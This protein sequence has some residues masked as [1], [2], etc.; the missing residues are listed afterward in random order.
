MKMNRFFTGLVALVAGL[1]L[2]AGSALATKGYL[3]GD[4]DTM[5]VIPHYEVGYGKATIIGISNL[6]S[7]DANDTECFARA[8]PGTIDAPFD[9]TLI[10]TAGNT[11]P[12]DSAIA[13]DAAAPTDGTTFIRQYAN[14]QATAN[15]DANADDPMNLI[16]T[17]NI[18]DASGAMVD[19]EQLC[20]NENQFGY[21][22]IQMGEAM[23]GQMIPH[24]GAVVSMMDDDMMD[25]DMMPRGYATIEATARIDE[26]A[27]GYVTP[28][29][30]VTAGDSVMP[31]IAA[32]TIVQDV[33]ENGFFGTEVPTGTLSMREDDGAMVADCYN[34]DGTTE[35]PTDLTDN[36]FN[37]HKCGLIPERH[38]TA[39]IGTDDTTTAADERMNPDPAEATPRAHVTARY[40]I[41][42]D[43]M[44][45]VWLAAEPSAPLEVMVLCE[46][47][48]QTA[49]DDPS[50]NVPTTDLPT[51][52]IAVSMGTTIIDPS[53]GEVGDFTGM[54]D[55]TRGTLRFAMPDDSH[56]GMVWTHLS[57]EMNHFRMNFPG[58]SLANPSNCNTVA[59][60]SLDPADTGAGVCE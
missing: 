57:Q 28:D 38:N 58:Y 20:L 51:A 10:T 46:E 5:K 9:T 3:S 21:V 37:Q 35:T 47:G 44:V 2:S 25:G 39:R 48:P 60:A 34:P 11:C 26:C 13:V 29:E 14:Y 18:H 15:M 41:G 4:P 7:G 43:S 31:M 33:S 50:S 45:Y 54:C 55:G 53:M 27:E 56:A 32:W 6:E 40:D 36:E 8:D 22:V 12:Y 16:V 17:M 30:A 24:R 59:I 23:E 19:S 52:E 1:A 42:G 49:L